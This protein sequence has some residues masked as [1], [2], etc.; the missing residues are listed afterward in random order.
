MKKK[1]ILLT[2]FLVFAS[3]SVACA[4]GSDYFA[5]DSYTLR[6]S[7]TIEGDIF[8]FA[9]D[10]K[11]YGQVKGS[12]FIVGSNIKITGDVAE[13]VFV[14]GGDVEISGDVSGDTRI[15]AGNIGLSGAFVGMVDAFGADMDL[16]GLF[17]GAVN[18]AGADITA[19]GEFLED[20]KIR[21]KTV[22][23]ASGASF[24]KDVSYTAK[25]SFIE[26]DVIIVGNLNEIIGEEA[27]A[28]AKE[29]KGPGIWTFIIFWSITLV[30]I[31]IVGLVLG[32]IF[33]K[34]V[35]GVTSSVYED[36]L[37]NL[38]WGVLV[39][40]LTPLAIFIMLITIIGVPLAVLTAITYGV[41]LYLGKLFV[42]I[43]TGGF[44]FSLFKGKKKKKKEG[45][46]FWLTLIVGVFVVYIILAIPILDIF[47]ALLIYILGLGTIFNYIVSKKGQGAVQ[48]KAKA[49]ARKRTTKR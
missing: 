6:Q 5:G 7:D 46:P 41:G 11:I 45:G 2:F 20:V 13:D 10:V 3:I 26:E 12:A 21:A 36:F 8:I 17:S 31:I 43:A 18:V 49:P 24:A 39:F 47:V 16:S 48:V 19:S 42:A 14:I 25:E 15:F 29:A 34:F 9:A 37:G 40:L 28:K 44:V 32:A 35:K 33:P 1:V 22:T 27:L 30:G 4:A 23:L 38:G